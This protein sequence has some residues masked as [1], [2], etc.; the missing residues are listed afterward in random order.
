MPRKP[1]TPSVTADV[2]ITPVKVRKAK[3][4][5]I[6]DRGFGRRQSTVRGSRGGMSRP[7][8]GR[9]SKGPKPL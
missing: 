1:E 7:I 4:P 3:T 6:P 2:A 9:R 5:A 8:T